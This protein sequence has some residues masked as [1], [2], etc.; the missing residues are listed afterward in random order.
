[1]Q[2]RK[3]DLR[4][5]RHTRLRKMDSTAVTWNAGTPQSFINVGSISHDTAVNNIDLWELR[6]R[7][8]QIRLPLRMNNTGAYHVVA[9]SYAGGGRERYVT[10][11]RQPRQ[12]SRNHGHEHQSSAIQGHLIV[13][14][15]VRA[16]TNIRFVAMTDKGPISP[17][18]TA[19]LSTTAEAQG[20]NDGN[21]INQ[22]VLTPSGAGAPSNV[23]ASCGQTKIGK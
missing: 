9:S 12:F 22:A 3:H 13:R 19:S 5:H 14:W 21:A 6:R 17:P 10:E 2:R 16:S 8:I 11:Y 18:R 1:M 4:A 20:A 23:L 15:T 7:L